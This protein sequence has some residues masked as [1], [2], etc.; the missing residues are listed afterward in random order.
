MSAG[1]I[2]FLIIAAVRIYLKIKE[3]V[4]ESKAKQQQQPG[5]GEYTPQPKQHHNPTPASKP[6]SGSIEEMLEDLL[7][8]A[9]ANKRKADQKYQKPQAKPAAELDMMGRPIKSIEY[10]DAPLD[11]AP[12]VIAPKNYEFTDELTGST[13]KHNPN[14]TILKGKPATAGNH[15]RKLKF[16]ARKAI[17][18]KELLDRKYFEV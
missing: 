9:E 17:L 16:N 14:T 10:A 7:E 1:V 3:A 8:K 18:Y 6:A 11:V 12:E 5:Y 15:K 2:I 13:L 4:D